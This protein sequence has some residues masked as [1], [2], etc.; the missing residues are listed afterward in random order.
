MS[1]PLALTKKEPSKLY[2]LVLHGPPKRKNLLFSFCT[3]NHTTR[4]PQLQAQQEARKG[5]EEEEREDE[6]EERRKTKTRKKER[7]GEGKER[8]RRKER[9]TKRKRQN[10]TQLSR[11]WPRENEDVRVSRTAL[12][13]ASRCPRPLKETKKGG[14]C[15]HQ[16]GENKKRCTLQSLSQTAGP[17]EHCSQN[18]VRT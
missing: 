17:P 12:K 13:R 5:E 4:L 14:A 9:K 10:L 1:G 15:K 16:L 7:R 18:S 2:P 6:E 11:T 8:E 3:K